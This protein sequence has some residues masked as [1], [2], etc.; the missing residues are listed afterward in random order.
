MSQHEPEGVPEDPVSHRVL[1]ALDELEDRP[2]DEHVAVLEQVNRTI[3]D[4]LAALDEV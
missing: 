1:T 2:V 4:E 3:A